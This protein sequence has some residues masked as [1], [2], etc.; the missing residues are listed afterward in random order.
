MENQKQETTWVLESIRIDLITYGN[1]KG[2]YRGSIRFS[3][4]D[5]DE[6]TFKLN[7]TLANV[8]L[9]L[10]KDTVVLSAN[11]LAEKLQKSLNENK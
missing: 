6:F 8:Y 3:N 4:N 11:Q 10:I 2:K 1:D 7:P 5:F 9:E